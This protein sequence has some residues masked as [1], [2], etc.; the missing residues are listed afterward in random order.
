MPTRNDSNRCQN[1][2]KERWGNMRLVWDSIHQHS[3]NFIEN[4]IKKAAVY[5]GKTG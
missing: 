4:A 3:Y 1:L 2:Q 5:E